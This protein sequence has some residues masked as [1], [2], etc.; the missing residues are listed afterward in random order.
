ME[1]GE[2][3]RKLASLQT[4]AESSVI[5]MDRGRWQETQG[6]LQCGDE[7]E[8]QAWLDTHKGFPLTLDRLLP[9]MRDWNHIMK[10]LGLL[11]EAL[12]YAA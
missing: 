11:V 12:K 3:S 1:L 6:R 10:D 7:K 2:Y 4:M 5:P 9:E 8:L